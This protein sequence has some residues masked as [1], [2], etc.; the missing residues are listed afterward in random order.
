MPRRRRKA[1]YCAPVRRG[2]DRALRLRSLLPGPR[3]GRARDRRRRALHGGSVGS[4]D[5][6]R[7]LFGSEGYLV[8]KRPVKSTFASCSHGISNEL[9]AGSSAAKIPANLEEAAG[10]EPGIPFITSD[11]PASALARSSQLRPLVMPDS[12]D[13]SGLE[14]TWEDDLVDGWWTFRML[15]SSGQPPR[16]RPRRSASSRGRGSCVAGGDEPRAGRARSI[17]RPA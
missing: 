3:A 2:R 16:P 4:F 5:S 9:S 17:A 14:V 10:L 12:T 1:R 15:S 8:R 6:A 7:G 13:W 11:G